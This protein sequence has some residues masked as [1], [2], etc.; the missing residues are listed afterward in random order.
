MPL[1]LSIIVCYQVF[2]GH[3][4]VVHVLGLQSET[5]VSFGKLWD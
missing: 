2:Y 1:Q 4:T 5:I 3:I